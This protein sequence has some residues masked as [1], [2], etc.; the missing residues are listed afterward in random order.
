M[1]RLFI[2][3]DT[4]GEIDWQKLNTLHFPVQ[5][6]LTK[7]DYVLICGDF[8]AIWSG[9]KSDKYLQETYASRN[10]TTLFVDG[11]HENHPMIATYPVEEWHG[12][13][14]HRINDSIIHLM[15]GQV[16][17]ICGKK[18][19][20]FGGARSVDKYLRTMGVD[21]WPEEMP[22]KDEMWTAIHNLE[23]CGNKVDIIV[24]HCAPADIVGEM[25]GIYDTDD[26]TSFLRLI[27]HTVDFKDWYFGHYHVDMDLDQY[28][29][30]YQVIDEVK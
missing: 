24:T 23:A 17:D 29:A 13:L 15:R 3:G 5:K 25:F 27:Q 11:N 6:S 21:W 30:R 22:S 12:G 26:C 8:G 4:H 28:H 9:D 16:Y 10:F 7:D 20:T 1:G 14:V 19:F 2:T 18:V